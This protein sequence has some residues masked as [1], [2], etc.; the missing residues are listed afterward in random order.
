[1]EKAEDG[2]PLGDLH[3]KLNQTNED[4]IRVKEHWDNAQGKLEEQEK[5]LE[6]VRAQS[7][8]RLQGLEEC[9]KNEKTLLESQSGR[10]DVMQGTLQDLQKGTVCIG[11]CHFQHPGKCDLY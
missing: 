7:E 11:Q 6:A 2:T 3:V 5:E 4:L 10:I 1:M 9:T 8:Q